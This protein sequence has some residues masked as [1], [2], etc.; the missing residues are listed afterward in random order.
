MEVSPLY[1][2]TCLIDFARA[3]L[4]NP[5]PMSTWIGT[6]GRHG[7]AQSPLAADIWLVANSIFALNWAR[8][9]RAVFALHPF[10]AVIK[11]QIGGRGKHP[12]FLIH[13]FSYPPKSSSLITV[14]CRSVKVFVRSTS[15]QDELLGQPIR[16]KDEFRR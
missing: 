12:M 9:P 15:R 4:Q 7:I 5:P 11:S 2:N 16:G 6:D 1:Y 3:E 14:Y 10:Q 13:K 8:L